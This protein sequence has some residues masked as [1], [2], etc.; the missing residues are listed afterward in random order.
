[1]WKVCK[2]VTSLFQNMDVI[3]Q[4][5]YGGSNLIW[6]QFEKCDHHPNLQHNPYWKLNKI[7]V[8][9]EKMQMA[10]INWVQ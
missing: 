7:L 6:I 1:M 10:S 4:E 3:M 2:M 5:Q 9:D 8:V